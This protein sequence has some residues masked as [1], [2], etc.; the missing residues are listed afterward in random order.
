M[1][2]VKRAIVSIDYIVND[3]CNAFSEI[4]FPSALHRPFKLLPRPQF[5]LRAPPEMF[6]LAGQ[7]L[8]VAALTNFDLGLRSLLTEAS[9]AIN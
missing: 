9:L 4:F 7:T 1:L 3:F 6:F 8:T 2:K 5:I